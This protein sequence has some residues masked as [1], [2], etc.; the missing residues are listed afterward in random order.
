MFKDW[1]IQ[2]NNVEREIW[3]V[4]DIATNIVETFS[5]NLIA[6]NIIDRFPPGALPLVKYLIR[7]WQE[8]SKLK[9]ENI[10]N[11]EKLDWERY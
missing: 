4:K 2:L 8:V 1:D 6:E 11:I 5:Q 10:M 7:Q 3:R 9:E